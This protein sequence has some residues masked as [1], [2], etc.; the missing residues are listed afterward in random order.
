MHLEPHATVA[1][2]S[3]PTQTLG[4]KFPF[5]Y[6]IPETICKHCAKCLIFCSYHSSL[7]CV[8]TVSPFLSIISETEL[9]AFFSI[10]SVADRQKQ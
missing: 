7:S 1:V 3:L 5:K 4:Y 6:L 9:Q 8:R 10:I 2:I